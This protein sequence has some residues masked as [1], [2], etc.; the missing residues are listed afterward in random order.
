M[1]RSSGGRT[2]EV[3]PRVGQR[4]TSVGAVA[5]RAFLALLVVA[6]TLAVGATR[7]TADP[8]DDATTTP[9]IAK[10]AEV[11]A[12][13]H[14]GSTT[15]AGA[16]DTVDWTI[17]YDGDAGYDA[18]GVTIEDPVTGPV[19]EEVVQ[20]TWLGVVRGIE[21]F[22]GRSSVK[23]W[24]FRILVFRAR[25]A[26]SHEHRNLPL[27]DADPLED[28]FG[29]GGAWSTPPTLWSDTVDD[30]LAAED[31]VRRVRTHL[32]ELPEAQR[33]VLVL[34][35]VEGLDA[36]DVCEVLGLTAGNQ[37][38]LLHRARTRLRAVLEAELAATG[39]G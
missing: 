12:G 20:D 10:S 39:E 34:R 14:A 5:G 38:V 26:G 4:S 17:A 28:R 11:A 27:D 13:P 8:G 15:T 36:D 25:S 21:R 16:G 6:S 32:P 37:R 19:A 18:D 24:L 3:S 22:E 23:T 9:A 29:P 31:L 1:A 33:R 30:R 7:A 2:Q 35:D